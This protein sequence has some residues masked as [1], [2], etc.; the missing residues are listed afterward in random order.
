MAVAAFQFILGSISTPS[1][2]AAFCS[3]YSVEGIEK[4]VSCEQPTKRV[5]DRAAK[6]YFR[7]VFIVIIINDACTN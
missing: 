6:M 3:A 4:S 5:I 2:S 7:F 1:F